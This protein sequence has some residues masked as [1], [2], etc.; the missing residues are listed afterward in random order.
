M[1]GSMQRNV[2]GLLIYKREDHFLVLDAR[3][4]PFREWGTLPL[5]FNVWQQMGQLR[6]FFLA[7]GK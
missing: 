5:Q 6:I 1:F 3:R 7:H 4:C 2:G